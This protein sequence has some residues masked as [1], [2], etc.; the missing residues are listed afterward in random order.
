MEIPSKINLLVVDNEEFTRQYWIKQLT[1]KNP[2]LFT[3]YEAQDAKSTFAILDKNPIDCV[4]LDLHLPGPSGI[5]IS[6][7]IKTDEKQK[8]TGIV[9]LTSNEDLDM[10]V[11]ALKTGVND[12]II[13]EHATVDI[14]RKSIQSAIKERIMEKEIHSKDRQLAY[15]KNEK[16]LQSILEISLKNIPMELLLSDILDLLLSSLT[17][18]PE[19]LKGSIFLVEK[20]ELVLKTKKQLPE[21]LQKMCARVP[22]GHC[23]C[24]RAAETKQLIFVDCIDHQHDISFEGIEE[25]G[26]Y[27]VPILSDEE[28]LGVVNLYVDHKTPFDSGLVS[29]LYSVG[30]TLAGVIERKNGEVKRKEMQ[31]QLLQSSKLATLGTFA[32]NITHDLNNPLVTIMGQ[33]QMMGKE[34]NVA[35]KTLER[36][37]SILKA[38]Q[39]MKGIIDH[40]RTFSRKEEDDIWGEVSIEEPIENA[41]MLIGSDLKTRQIKIQTQ[42]DEDLPFIWG[43]PVQLESVFQNLLANSR[44]AFNDQPSGNKQVEIYSHHYADLKMLVVIYKDNAGGMKPEVAKKIFDPFFTTKPKGVGTGI[45][46]SITQD[47]MSKHRGEISLETI[48]GL[49]SVFTI[50][51]PVFEG[52]KRRHSQPKEVLK[53][54]ELE[55]LKGQEPLKILLIDDQEDVAEVMAELM[56]DNFNFTIEN[57]SL[58]ALELVRAG[59]FDLILTDYKMPEVS[60]IKVMI[61]SKKAKPERPVIIMTGL[62]SD[63]PETQR[64]MDKGADGFLFKPLTD[65]DQAVAYIWQIYNQ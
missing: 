10:V 5:E 48:E 9:M 26:H 11:K 37:G 14:V 39:R 41:L 52:E 50:S 15:F 4:L 44:D 57:N 65:P 2:D 40:M 28:V 30:H 51:F 8:Y 42:F 6:E 49:G 43:D 55:V 35:P 60:G 45:G 31:S 19:Q 3:I 27:V 61:E 34:D 13:K 47:I 62:G 59:D 20:G 7:K 63:D 36:T 46:M 56:E 29:L 64:A 54:S 32:A 33:A 58:K 23:I 17:P 25:H 24:G 1:S 18:A 53:N 38:A 22:F 21:M 12:Y 16:V